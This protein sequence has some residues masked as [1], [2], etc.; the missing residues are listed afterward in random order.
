VPPLLLREAEKVPDAAL[1]LPAQGTA[2][3]RRRFAGF[4]AGE[5]SS[6]PP[7]SPPPAILRS[8]HPRRSAPG[9]SP[10]RPDPSSCLP[11]R[12]SAAPGRSLPVPGSRSVWP[13]PSRP[14]QRGKPTWPRALWSVALGQTDPGAKSPPHVFHFLEKLLQGSKTC[15]MHRKISI[16][17]KNAYDIP[18]CSEKYALHVYVKFIHC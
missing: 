18:K 1:F 17:Q 13:L 4:L 6:P 11:A 7:N 15:K 9:E 16:C 3:S 14:D 10:V 8:I 12:R 2:R 5:P